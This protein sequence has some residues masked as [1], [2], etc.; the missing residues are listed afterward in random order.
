MTPNSRSFIGLVVILY[1]ACS[2]TDSPLSTTQDIRIV[3]ALVG[4]YCLA[5]AAREAIEFLE[6]RGGQ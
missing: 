4:V 3:W 5:W 2:T 6:K 1:F